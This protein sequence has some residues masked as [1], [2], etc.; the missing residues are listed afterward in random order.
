MRLY[1]IAVTALAVGAPLKWADNL[2]AHHEIPEVRSRRRGVARGVSWAG[3][4]RIALIRA[5]HLKLGCGVQD[6]VALSHAL[7][8]APDGATK[9]GGLLT[10]AVDRT[11]L[12]HELRARLADVLESAP[13]PRRGRPPRRLSRGPAEE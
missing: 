8:Q 10:L 6:A 13:S 1:S 7:L 4:V 12:E 2:V 3:V 5:L 9:L 11:A